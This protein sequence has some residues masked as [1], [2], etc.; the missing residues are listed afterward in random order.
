[1]SAWSMPVMLALLLNQRVAGAAPVAFVL[2]QN[3]KLDELRD[4][5]QRRVRLTLLDLCVFGRCELAL[6]TIQ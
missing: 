1:M 2:R 3:A 5:T 6:E 4:V